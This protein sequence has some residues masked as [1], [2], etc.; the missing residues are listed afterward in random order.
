MK[1]YIFYFLMMAI[2][3]TGATLTKKLIPATE[4]TNPF[5]LYVK[6]ASVSVIPI[7]GLTMLLYWIMFSI[8]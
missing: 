4:N 3:F 6:R 5:Q 7:A 1:L 8:K 2:I